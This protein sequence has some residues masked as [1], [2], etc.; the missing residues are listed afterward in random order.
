M[1]CIHHFLI[2]RK[3]LF[4]RPNQNLKRINIKGNEKMIAEDQEH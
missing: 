4:G 3:K 1:L 2:K